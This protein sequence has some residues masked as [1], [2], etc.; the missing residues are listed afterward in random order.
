[1]APAA[2][3]TTM[4][5]ESFAGNEKALAELEGVHPLK[6]IADPDEI[7]RIALFLASKDSSFLTGATIFADG[8][9]LSRLHDPA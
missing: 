2:T 7:A 1:L 9:I 5:K 3:A 8:G 4:L 6:R